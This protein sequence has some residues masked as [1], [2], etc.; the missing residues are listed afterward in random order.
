MTMGFKVRDRALLDKLPEGRT[1]EFDFVKCEAGY[2]ITA[3]R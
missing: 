1:V 3:V 2:A